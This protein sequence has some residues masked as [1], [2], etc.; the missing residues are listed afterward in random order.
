[1]ETGEIDLVYCHL[2]SRKKEY[3]GWLID[4]DGEEAGELALLAT[5]AGKQEV[6][7]VLWG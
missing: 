1:M 4:S 6:E 3:R 7:K 5:R 2:V